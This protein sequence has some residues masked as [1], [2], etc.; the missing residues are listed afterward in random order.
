M[1]RS[2][3][4]ELTAWND[5]RPHFP[6]QVLRVV[7]LATHTAERT[8]WPLS[9]EVQA[10]LQRVDQLLTGTPLSTADP[11]VNSEI[12]RTAVSIGA[13]SAL[14]R[15]VQSSANCSQPGPTTDHCHEG[16]FECPR[17]GEPSSLAA[18]STLALL[19]TEDEEAVA[20]R[21]WQARE[22]ARWTRDEAE[23]AEFRR[24]T[25]GS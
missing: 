18:S 21:A 2:S 4:C 23:R 12:K 5:V 19:A 9:E 6:A 10:A 8:T 13:S 17:P 14:E 15:C 3:E 1:S 7:P 16:E 24:F 11:V 22:L 25:T 20:R